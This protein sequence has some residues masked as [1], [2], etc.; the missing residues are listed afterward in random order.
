M[1]LNFM[2]N[3]HCISCLFFGTQN[4]FEIIFGRGR[5]MV[6]ICYSFMIFTRSSVKAFVSLDCYLLT[7]SPTYLLTFSMEQSPSWKAKRFSASQET[8]RIL[9][10]RKFISAVTSACHLSVSWA[11]SNQSM[12]PHP[13]CWRSILIFS[14]LCLVFPNGLFPSGFPTKTLYKTLHLPICATCPANLSLDFITQTMLGEEYRSL[15]SALCSFFHYPVTSSLLGPDIFLNTLFPNTLAL[16]SSLS[17]SNQVSHPY[18][19]TGKIIILCILI[20]EFLDSKVEDKRF[21]TE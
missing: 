14:H 18:K 2:S 11:T 20:F 15:S 16:R 1:C 9:W 5:M 8:P 21:C 19:M 17:V 10:T 7:Y 13:I 4:S 3:V 6:L 12:L